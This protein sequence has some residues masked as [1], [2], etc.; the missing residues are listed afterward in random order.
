MSQ[1]PHDIQQQIR[2]GRILVREGQVS[3]TKIIFTFYSPECSEAGIFR[4]SPTVFKISCESASPDTARTS[5]I[6]PTHTESQNRPRSCRPL[7]LAW[8]QPN[9]QLKVV[10]DLLGGQRASPLIAT[11]DYPGRK[12]WWA[13]TLFTRP[14]RLK[15]DAQHREEHSYSSGVGSNRSRAGRSSL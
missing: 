4:R 6:A 9:N 7:V 12:Y 8:Q 1:R 15:S 10:P 13:A 5:A 2:H 11:C 14:S 3:V